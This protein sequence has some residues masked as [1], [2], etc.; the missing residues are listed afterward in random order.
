MKQTLQESNNYIFHRFNENTVLLK[1]VGFPQQ[2][3]ELWAVPKNPAAGYSINIDGKEYE[4]VGT[5]SY[6]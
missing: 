2:S 3:A 6:V 4:Y 5:T 1:T